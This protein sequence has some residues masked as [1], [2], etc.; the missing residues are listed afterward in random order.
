MEMLQFHIKEFPGYECNGARFVVIAHCGDW[1]DGEVTNDPRLLPRL[2][3]A[4]RK[5]FMNRFNRQAA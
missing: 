2:E 4:L 3:Q 5:R 1:R